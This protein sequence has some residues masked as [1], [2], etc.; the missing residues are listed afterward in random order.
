[1]QRR[2]VLGGGLPFVAEAARKRD[3]VGDHQTCVGREMVGGRRFRIV[4]VD[5]GI[6]LLWHNVRVEQRPNEMERAQRAYNS[7][8]DCS[9]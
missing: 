5:H 3:A 6:A 7:S 4:V 9:N 8:A 2:R 1:M